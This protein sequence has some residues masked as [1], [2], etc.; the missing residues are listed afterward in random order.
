MNSAGVI[1]RHLILATLSFAGIAALAAGHPQAS[2]SVAQQQPTTLRVTTRLVTINAVVTDK[3]GNPVPDLTKDDFSIVDGGH[4][5]KIQFFSVL[6][7]Q[8]PSAPAPMPPDTYTNVL[9]ERGATPPS[10]TVIL[11]DAL[12]TLWVG[13]GY[14]LEKVREFLRHV[15][16]EDRVGLFVIGKEKLT[17]LHDVNENATTLSD[18]IRRYDARHKPNAP[19][20]DSILDNHTTEL[21]RFLEGRDNTFIAA[22]DRPSGASWEFNRLSTQMTLVSMQTV[23][24]HLS[25]IP[26]RKSLIWITDNPRS[27]GSLMGDSWLFD[28]SAFAKQQRARERTINLDPGEASTGTSREEADPHQ[29]AVLYPGQ[30]LDIEMMV[31]LMNDAGIAIYPVD[32]EGL[33]APTLGFTTPE[34]T[35]GSGSVAKMGTTENFSMKEL[36]ERT[37]GRAFYNRNDLDMGIRRA[38]NDSRLTYSV[39]YYPDH[40][41][42]NGSFR[43]IQIKIDR[44]G[45]SVLARQ[46]YFAL[47]DATPIPASYRADY[48]EQ[49]AASPLDATEFPMSVH[50]GLAGKKANPS[51]LATL[52]F[53]AQPLL[54][55]QSD[56]D[57][58]SNFEILFMQMDAKNK[59]LDA[60]NKIFTGSFAQSAYDKMIRAPMSIP[61]ALKFMPHATVLC[62]ILR[63]ANS[64]SIGSVHIPLEKYMAAAGLH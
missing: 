48:M 28:Q 12:N 59:L 54:R 31:R 62:V 55:L 63:D 47:A 40:N 16:P 45:V 39:G 57:W 4:Q 51:L 29:A 32:A 13:Q 22:R 58:T 56:G 43:K 15:Q 36:A 24:R 6:T 52:R 30:V 1:R 2:Q 11:F 53:Q 37:G 41:Q 25:T 19:V 44:P 35:A 23:V 7:N 14:A 49:I 38:I 50:I 64:E 10:V 18:A 5:Q 61:V 20:V 3:Q 9:A 42:W 26:G 21:E 46:G 33:Q 8:P 17:I 27:S 34:Q 60:T